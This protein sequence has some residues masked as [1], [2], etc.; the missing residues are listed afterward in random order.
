MLWVRTTSTSLSSTFHALQLPD[1]DE[2]ER[3]LDQR[4]ATR[5]LLTDTRANLWLLR[6]LGTERSEFTDEA[7][8]QAGRLSSL[9]LLGVTDDGEQACPVCGTALSDDDI[10]QQL[11]HALE[12]LSGELAQVA[13]SAPRVD[14]ATARIQGEISE[15]EESLRVNAFALRAVE[16]S[17]EE[18]LV[19]R[20]DAGRS[21]S[22][23]PATGSARP[24]RCCTGCAWRRSRTATS[25]TAMTTCFVVYRGACIGCG[26][27]GA[28]K[29]DGSNTALEDALD[30]ALPQ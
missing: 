6:H 12:G 18:M 27:A 28:G 1:E 24:S 11:R 10:V 26:W 20:D 4:A 21:A 15:I 13:A 2:Y 5:T 23:G 22:P 30:H 25:P 7:T 14:E 9:G 3:L 16:Q 29:H 17:H 8:E 19:Y